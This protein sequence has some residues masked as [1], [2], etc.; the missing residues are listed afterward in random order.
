MGKNIEDQ[1][2]KAVGNEPVPESLHPEQIEKMLEGRKPKRFSYRRLGAAAAAVAVIAL[3]GGVGFRAWH[4]NQPADAGK[5]QLA[6]FDKTEVNVRDPGIPEGVTTAKN[7]K[8]V[9][10]MLVRSHAIQSGTENSIYEG[11]I[12]YDSVAKD[13]EGGVMDREEAA[14]P[15]P[16]YPQGESDI[17]NDTND[18][19]LNTNVNES[20]EEEDFSKVNA[21]V[22]GVAEA[23]IM[24]TDG[25]YLY[26][27]H[28]NENR[29]C[30]VTPDKQTGALTLSSDIDLGETIHVQEMYIQNGKLVILADEYEQSQLER[31]HEEQSSF[32]DDLLFGVT[33][34]CVAYPYKTT[35]YAL[36]IT[37][38]VSD[39][40]HPKEAGRVKMDGSY[41]DSRLVDGCLYMFSQYNDFYMVKDNMVDDT[42]SY[43]PC[44]QDS[45]IA[46]E[47]IFIPD[48]EQAQGY[49][50]G[51]S[52]DINEPSQARDEFAVMMYGSQFY[53]SQGNIY[54]AQDYDGLQ[55]VRFAYQHGEIRAE[56]SGK[57]RG[58]INDS[59]SMDEYNGYLRL[60]TTSYTENGAAS[61]V[62]ED[63][64]AYSS[65]TAEISVASRA[66]KT[67]NN[68]YVLDYNLN[69]V[70]QIEDL[71]PDEQIYSARFMGDIGY[72]VTYREVDPL[73][74]VD[75]SHPDSPKVLGELK[76]SGF[77]E[78][79]HPYGDG[80]LLGIG[81]ETSSNGYGGV[82]QDG[83]KLSMF[84]TSDPSDV[85]E[86]ARMIQEDV[87][88]TGVGGS[89][90]TVMIS[91]NKN[92]FGFCI[93]T[94]KES[95]YCTYRYMEG[96]GF[97]KV[98]D[99]IMDNNWNYWGTRGVF[100]KDVLYISDGTHV[101]S[102][103]LTDGSTLDELNL[104]QYSEK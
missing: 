50:V 3:A 30:I 71:A 67:V 75:L 92:L 44:V 54:I 69:V 94:D 8:Q 84:D 38:D 103:S 5:G 29:I 15:S 9:F 102:V 39:R 16:E 99:T 70:G 77:S 91:A 87:I 62:M 10:D 19:A 74:S 20:T 40:E 63:V 51:V 72:F 49:L 68:L 93:Q 34:D 14:A 60:V 61:G 97:E 53:V 52:V 76:I 86:I 82:K 21:Q 2:K 83:L 95:R 13:V 1:V 81:W 43:I 23:D 7:Y 100:I 17:Y 27:C 98:T 58:W 25:A 89:H 101:Y 12:G 42:E 37:Y 73:F 28:E 56:A 6:D 22:E 59:F 4:N 96:V 66:G 35:I 90:H 11:S 26:L 45:C 33:S 31:S 48:T 78:Y 85:S 24:V 57:V 46:K 104:T 36:A 32:V 64:E 47:R 80:R 41:M 55:L 88:S 65:E 79:L 18:T